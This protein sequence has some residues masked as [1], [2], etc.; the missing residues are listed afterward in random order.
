MHWR[1]PNVSSFNKKK[2]IYSI[3]NISFSVD[4]VVKNWLMWSI[5]TYKNDNVD[6]EVRLKSV[7][8]LQNEMIALSKLPQCFRWLVKSGND[9]MLVSENWNQAQILSLENKLS[10]NSFL[11]Q[12]FYSQA[13]QRR[14]IQIHSSLIDY[15]GSGVMFLGP[16]GIGKTTQAELWNKYL[17]ASIINGDMVF[18]ED[19]GDEFIGWGTPW[20]GSSPYCENTN[21]PIKALIVLKQGRENRLRR[22][23]E[24]EMVSEVIKNVIY[25][26]WL[27]NGTELALETLDHIL[28]GVPVYELVN[29]ADE[30]SVTMVKQEVFG[31]EKD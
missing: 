14:M 20:H 21:L 12:L 6:V 10:L 11:L 25:P 28:R 16:S 2:M 19:R 17:E 4:S 24:F 26:M 22:L 15:H 7:N 27:E 31:N 5:T 1:L 3:C 18:V 23:Y 29:R 8:L 9:I 30:E 13:V